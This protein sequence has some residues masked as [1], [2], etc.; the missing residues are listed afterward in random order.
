MPLN[1]IEVD[2]SGGHPNSLGDT[3]AVVDRVLADRA[4]LDDLVAC[5]RS[6]DPV[7]RL[8]VSSALKRIS[9]VRPEWLVPYLDHLLTSVAFLE[10]ASAKWTLAILFDRLQPNMTTDQ[11]RAAVTVMQ[12]NL[13]SDDDW[14]VQNTSMQ[15]LATWAGS[16]EAL[17]HWLIPRLKRFTGSPRKS[18]ANRARR[19]LD[20]PRSE[21]N[22]SRTGEV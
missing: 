7:V 16:D 4:L 21:R 5:Y 12:R 20:V 11:R 15:V 2:L 17:R 22:V 10:Q 9:A 14:I 6:D 19:L 8:R 3:V 1:A 13:D 18:V